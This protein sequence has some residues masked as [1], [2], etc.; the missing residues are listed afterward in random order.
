M[1]LVGY[2]CVAD[3]LRSVGGGGSP[4]E[5]T[6]CAPSEEMRGVLQDPGEFAV[7]WKAVSGQNVAGYVRLVGKR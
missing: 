1:C 5:V 4:T 2:R 7:E 6:V 3:I